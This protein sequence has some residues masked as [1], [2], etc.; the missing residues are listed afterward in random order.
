[1]MSD[2]PASAAQL[3]SIPFMRLESIEHGKKTLI[4]N[5]VVHV[6]ESDGD[7]HEKTIGF[8]LDGKSLE[9]KTH[10]SEYEGYVI[11]EIRLD[12][13]AILFGNGMVVSIENTNSQD[14]AALLTANLPA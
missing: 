9:H 14:A 10:L 7:I 4:A 12:E 5:L 11:E 2:I 1:M 6:L 13:R 3:G 8:G